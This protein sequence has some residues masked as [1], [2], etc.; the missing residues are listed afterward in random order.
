MG[1]LITRTWENPHGSGL[2]R[3]DRLSGEYQA[4]LPSP[5]QEIALQL[6]P[7]IAD[8]ANQAESRVRSLQ[9]SPVLAAISRFL[10]HSEAIAS[11]QIEGI[12]PAPKQVALAELDA[13]ASMRGLS[14]QARLAAN[15]VRVVGSA[16]EEIA[17][18]PAVTLAHLLGLHRSLLP[19]S[20][21]LHG[22]RHTQNWVGGSA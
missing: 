16:A 9:H 22:L 2:R 14:E 6:D 11:S 1:T 18:A 7:R 3:R 8:L 21:D 4:Y 10:L 17:A 12:S 19:D 5:L 13:G 15:N 20:P